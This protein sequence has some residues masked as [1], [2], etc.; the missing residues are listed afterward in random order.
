MAGCAATGGPSLKLNARHAVMYFKSAVPPHPV[1]S[2]LSKLSRN[3]QDP[4]GPL[5][6][7]AQCSTVA[8]FVGAVSSDFNNIQS[9]NISEFG[10]FMGTLLGYLQRRS[11]ILYLAR[12]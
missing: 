1:L 4:H 6:S 7:S 10:E 12:D 8:V 11:V 3:C 2:K 5:A 9:F